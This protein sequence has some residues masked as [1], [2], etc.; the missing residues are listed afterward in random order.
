[1]EFPEL[2]GQGERH[3]QSL[4]RER[5]SARY[6]HKAGPRV[7]D[8]DEAKRT[9]CKAEGF[10]LNWWKPEAPGGCPAEEEELGAVQN[11]SSF[12]LR[13]QGWVLADRAWGTEASHLD[14]HPSIWIF[15]HPAGVSKEPVTQCE[16]YSPTHQEALSSRMSSYI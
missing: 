3:S 2:S 7:I 15:S 8:R 6:A 13:Q 9:G 16:K 4:S 10:G 12:A 14:M 1:M 11:S 5:T